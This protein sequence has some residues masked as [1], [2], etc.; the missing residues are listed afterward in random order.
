MEFMKVL[1]TRRSVRAFKPDPLPDDVLARILEGA[2][3]AP[4]AN[5]TQPWR[6]IVVRDAVKRQAI[7]PLTSGHRF[8]SQ[9]PV[10]VVCCGKRY[11]D[12]YSWIGSNMYLVDCAIA[13]DHLTLAARNEGV[14]SCWIGA[15]KHEAI[16]T[17]VGVPDGYDV[18]MVIPLGY[19]ALPTAFHDA[20]MRY[21]LKSIMTEI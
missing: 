13:I 21:P 5:N 3:V 14:G 10:I 9:A 17:A 8:V 18:I 19:P 11:N 4:S 1:K 7:A 16:K 20:T 12:L 2:R 6:F 15:F